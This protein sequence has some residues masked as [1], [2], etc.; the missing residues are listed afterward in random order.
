MARQHDAQLFKAEQR[1]GD[2]ERWPLAGVHGAVGNNGSR[3]VEADGGL[4]AQGGEAATLIQKQQ[5]QLQEQ[6]STPINDAE[7]SKEVA[8]VWVISLPI[9]SCTL[10]HVVAAN[11]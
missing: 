5:Q 1:V 7:A 8:E 2:Q 4:S 10:L 11:A 6:R 9:A 3:H